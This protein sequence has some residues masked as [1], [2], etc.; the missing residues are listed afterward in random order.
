MDE[1]PAADIFSR[2]GIRTDVK[3]FFTEVIAFSEVHVCLPRVPKGPAVFCLVSGCPR[4][5]IRHAG[6]TGA[7]LIKMRLPSTKLVRTFSAHCRA[8]A[9]PVSW[10]PGEL[11]IAIEATQTEGDRQPQA[12]TESLCYLRTFSSL[13]TALVWRSRVPAQLPCVAQGRQE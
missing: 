10:S 8:A 9:Q 4:R 13:R 1:Q 2:H 6:S 11:P 5:R 3:V 12:A 7:A